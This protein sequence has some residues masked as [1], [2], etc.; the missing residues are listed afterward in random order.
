[1]NL[2]TKLGRWV[3]A[4]LISTEQ[5]DAIRAVEGDAHPRGRV[6]LASEA[7]GYVGVALV[8]GALLVG[9]GEVWVDLR[10]GSRSAVLAVAT[11]ALVGAGWNLRNNPEPALERLGGFLWFA[12]AGS[13]F[14]LAFII[15]ERVLG[16]ED[17]TS[18]SVGAGVLVAMFAFPLWRLRPRGLQQIA[19]VAGI[20]VALFAFGFNDLGVNG[21]TLAGLL[22][23]GFG[24]IWLLGSQTGWV[25][26]RRTGE[27]LGSLSVLVGMQTTGF[28]EAGWLF[29]GLVVQAGILGLGIVRDRN[30]LLGF[31]AAGLL[32]LVPQFVTEAFGASLSAAGSV[33]IV[34]ALIVGVAVFMGRSRKTD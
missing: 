3:S 22:V 25:V 2:E 18:A 7:L 27:A 23:A 21:E 5:A 15:S 34:G 9:F 11:A 6:S 28:D 24:A 33:A 20:V 4:G 30:V 10:F 13:F 17:E 29:I 16:F 12:S 1:M 32:L 8:I 19:L 26:P 14:G 31:G